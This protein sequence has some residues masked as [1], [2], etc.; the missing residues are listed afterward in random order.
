[1]RKKIGLVCVALAIAMV[2]PSLS[3]VGATKP[4]TPRDTLVIGL[5]IE[6]RDIDPATATDLYSAWL[7]INVYERLVDYKPGTLEIE[8]CLATSWDISEDGLTYTFH[9]RHGVE[10]TDG[11]PMNATAVKYSLDRATAMN[12]GLSW[13]LRDVIDHIDALDESTVQITLKHPHPPFLGCLAHHVGSIVTPGAVEAHGGIKP[14]EIN[15]WMSRHAIATGPFK[16]DRWVPATEIVLTANKDHWR[17]PPK[18]NK[19]VMRIIPE[20][21]TLKMMFERGELDIVTGRGGGLDAKDFPAVE[22]NPDLTIVRLPSL[23]VFFV[24]TNC[25][26]KPFDDVRVREAVNYAIEYEAIIR[27]VWYGYASRSS[28]PVPETMTGHAD[29]V[30]VFP[31]D[32]EKARALLKEAG[33]GKGFETTLYCRSEDAIAVRQATIIQACLK[34]VGIKMNIRQVSGPTYWSIVEREG[35]CPMFVHG[36]IADYV[37]PLAFMMPLYHSRNWG[38]GGNSAFYKNDDVDELLDKIAVTIDPNERAKL[39]KQAQRM[40]AEDA[41]YVFTIARDN[42]HCVGGWVKDFATMPM[43]LLYFYPVYKEQ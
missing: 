33:Y 6:P 16:L 5:N 14:S 15:E 24:G 39:C 19:I 7:I 9:L 11:T 29:D 43:D 42:L 31:H 34:D 21:S 3:I 22:Q 25:Q 37:D 4:K 27:D 32:P 35:E 12:L 10:F 40:I 36:W 8:P 23:S 20:V 17:E 41:P 30:F 26:M 18:M 28:G 38:P 13:I 2:M 1:M